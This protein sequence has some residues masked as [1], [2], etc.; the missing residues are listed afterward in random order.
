[1]RR[2]YDLRNKKSFLVILI[3]M[4]LVVFVFSL[5]IY[6]Y[7]KALKVEYLVESGAIIQDTD[8]NYIQ[9]DD[10]AKLKIRWNDNYYLVYQDKEV[11]LGKK[12]IVYNEITGSLKLYGDFYEIQEDGTIVKNL[13]ETILPNTTNTK[14]YKLADREYLVVDREIKS[15]DN[16]VQASNYL[17]VE[18][19]K[20]GNAKLSNNKVNLKTITPTILVTAKYRFDIN[21]ETINFGNYDIDLKKIIGTTNQYVPE[22]DDDDEDTTD[23]GESNSSGNNQVGGNGSS[24][25]GVVNNGGSGND[26]SDIEDIKDKTKMTSVVRVTSGLSQIEVD[27]VVYDP[28][29][30]YKSVYVEIL[31]NGKLEVIYLSKNDTHVVFDNLAPDTMYE[32]SFVY[33]TSNDSGEI[34]RNT[35]DKMNIT[36]KKPEYSIEVYKVSSVNNTITYKVYLES[37]YKVDNIKVNLSFDYYEVNPTDGSTVKKSASIDDNLNVS[38]S[39]KY[40]MGTFDISGYNIDKNTQLKLSVVNVSGSFGTIDINS[41]YSFKFGR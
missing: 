29:N 16:N 30:E 12:V 8:K 24:G 40:I 39:L 3:L 32:L 38:E 34:I 20:L 27:Y 18:L 21:N 6:K 31:K 1:M 10:D 4:V 5:F 33:T 28:Y 22:E 25:S 35:F 7:T 23:N 13:D 37:G 15:S 17:L 11:S 41:S 26:N 36:T 14:F 9:V 2:K 19:D